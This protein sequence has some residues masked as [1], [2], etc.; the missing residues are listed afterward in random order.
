MHTIH[1]QFCPILVFVFANVTLSTVCHFGR[2]SLLQCN[3][4]A[5]QNID[6]NCNSVCSEQ[7]LVQDVIS[8]VYTNTMSMGELLFSTPKQSSVCVMS[9]V[10][11]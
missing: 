5:D 1:T 9:H 2:Y 3:L 6:I 10:D 4:W 11:Y 8:L 7:M